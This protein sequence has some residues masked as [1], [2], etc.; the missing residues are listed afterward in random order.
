MM[1]SDAMG[2]ALENKKKGLRLAIMIGPEDAMMEEKMKE[3]MPEGEY[4]DEGKG[5]EKEEMGEVSLN[6]AKNKDMD[7]EEMIDEDIDML[8]EKSELGM[9]M[10]EMMKKKK[11]K[12]V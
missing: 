3:E 12:A 4:E 6:E 11:E 7:E 2:D 5:E 1:K 10:K 8:P 9:R